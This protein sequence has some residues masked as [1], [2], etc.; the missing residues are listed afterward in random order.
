MS[1]KSTERPP[2]YVYRKGDALFGE[3]GMDREM[4]RAFPEGQ[5]IRVDLRTGRV[6]ERLRFYW[7][8]LAKVIAATECAPTKEALHDVIKLNTGF[9]TPV[10]VKGY[11]VLVP[12]SIS[13]DAMSEDEFSQ[14][15]ES[16][17]RWIAESYGVTP[18]EAFGEAA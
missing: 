14:F 3:M 1:K 11:T 12:R 15:L 16:A 18:E 17:I 10:N 8:F 7:A 13:F 9:T 4:I 5:R 2:I 6:P